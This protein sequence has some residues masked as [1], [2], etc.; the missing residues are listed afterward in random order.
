M[1]RRIYILS[2]EGTPN[3]ADILAIKSERSREYIRA[4]P[5]RQSKDFSTLYPQ[6]SLK[7]ID[8]LSKALVS[9]INL[10]STV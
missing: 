3:E 5:L 2:R 6:A 10:R 1:E 4:L 7:A 8:F 9:A